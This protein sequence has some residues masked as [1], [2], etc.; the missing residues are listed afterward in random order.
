MVR[1]VAVILSVMG[2]LSGIALAVTGQF[3]V[4]T[5]KWDDLS[6]EEKQCVLRYL[7]CMTKV[8]AKDMRDLV[9]EKKVCRGLPRK[10]ST[11]P[12]YGITNYDNKTGKVQGVTFTPKFFDAE[13]VIKK[14]AVIQ[15]ANR[16]RYGDYNPVPFGTGALGNSKSPRANKLQKC[17]Y[18]FYSLVNSGLTLA[19]DTRSRSSQVGLTAPTA[20]QEEE[21]EDPP[22]PTEDEVENWN[23]HVCG[24]LEKGAK[25]ALFRARWYKKTAE[26]K[27]NNE[28]DGEGDADETPDDGK[29]ENANESDAKKALTKLC[30][31]LD[32]ANAAIEEFDN[33]EGG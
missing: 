20:Q 11:R 16:V 1:G 27:F 18:D 14:S 9:D 19:R 4:R 8:D 25:R 30:K 33:K 5:K 17:Y 6:E 26:K 7:K 12:Q 23:E 31:E 2:A 24:E 10:E 3:A 29:N 32:K 15:E 21:G 28:L 13:M 22:E